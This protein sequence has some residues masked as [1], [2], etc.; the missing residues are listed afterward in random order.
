MILKTYK[1]QNSKIRNKLID[2]V[3]ST[4]NPNE[5]GI[6]SLIS[7]LGDFRDYVIVL[8]NNKKIL[9]AVSYYLSKKKYVGI[10]HIGVIDQH[11]GYG[12]MLMKEIFKLG[13]PVSLTTNGYSNEFY[14]K[15]GMKRVNDK[16]PAVYEI[17]KE[18]IICICMT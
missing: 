3:K 10:D 5:S 2:K 14:E 6:S 12:T 9:G 8:F 15:L 1:N 13:Y 4:Y 16:M 18:D 11:Q 17:K 7:A